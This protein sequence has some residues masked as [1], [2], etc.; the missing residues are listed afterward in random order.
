MR[1]LYGSLVKEAREI[2]GISQK[3]LADLTGKSYHYIS[4]IEENRVSFGIK[5][6]NNILSKMGFEIVHLVKLSK[7]DKPL[8]N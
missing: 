2:L 7:I 3:E 1:V 5:N 4:N 6:A 8:N